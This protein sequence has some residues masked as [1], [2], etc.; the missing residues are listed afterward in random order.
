ML[1]RL[2]SGL[3]F[4]GHQNRQLYKRAPFLENKSSNPAPHNIHPGIRASS[5]SLVYSRTLLILEPQVHIVIA[6]SKALHAPVIGRARFFLESV[7]FPCPTGHCSVTFDNVTARCH[8]ASRLKSKRDSGM[9][10]FPR[11]LN[12]RIKTV[13]PSPVP[14]C[15]VLLRRFDALVTQGL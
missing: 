2:H 13:L 7:D 1:Y 11:T 10:T 8:G 9:R 14:L 5:P 12:Q 6:R 3:L 15:V 4:L